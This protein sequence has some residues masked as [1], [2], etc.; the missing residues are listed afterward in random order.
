MDLN[1]ASKVAL[2]TGASKGIGAAVARG[3]AEEGVKLIVSARGKD[4]LE[5]HAATL[6]GETG[7]D[8][9]AIPADVSTLEGITTLF[10]AL[11]DTQPDILICNAGGPPAGQATNLTEAQW[12]QGYDLT[13]M[14]P[15]R[16]AYAALPTM[17]KRGWGRIINITSIS[18]REPVANLAL[19]NA[20][21]AAVTGFAKTL[22]HEVIAEGI[23]VNNVGPGYTDTER[24][25]Q[26]FGDA[27]AKSAFAQNIPAKRLA[28]PEEIASAA[29]FLASSQAAYIT[30][31]TLM[32]DGGALRGVS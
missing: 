26:L 2:V 30:G 13:L 21:R 17:R 9:T 23:T 32:V 3:L 27:A 24:L 7:A 25:N 11:G 4:V 29:I 1:I 22:S 28:T 6:H 5:Q 18:V 12:S 31:Q 10:E 20:Y 19:S 16:L 14:S 15:I 8:V